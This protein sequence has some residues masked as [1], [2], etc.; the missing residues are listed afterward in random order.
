[1]NH[2]KSQSQHFSIQ[3]PTHRHKLTTLHSEPASSAKKPTNKIFA[4][5]Q[6]QYSQSKDAI[7][8]GFLTSR[9]LR[10]ILK[11]N[12]IQIKYLGLKWDVVQNPKLDQNSLFQTKLNIADYFLN[13]KSGLDNK[14]IWKYKRFPQQHK[15]SLSQ[16]VQDY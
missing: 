9:R 16:E 2:S 4:I 12:S 5:H 14:N 3:R 8:N 6:K 15:N 7:Q 1:M 10:Q 11:P 13:Q